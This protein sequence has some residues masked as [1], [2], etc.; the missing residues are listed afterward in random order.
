MSAEQARDGADGSVPGTASVLVGGAAYKTA[1]ESPPLDTLEKV[2]R[3]V[4]NDPVFSAHVLKGW[5]H[6]QA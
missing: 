6:E 2:R 3:G 4:E 5:I 1:M